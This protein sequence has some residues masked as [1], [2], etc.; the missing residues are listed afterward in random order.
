MSLS[1]GQR[2]ELELEGP[3]GVTVAQGESEGRDHNIQDTCL[4]TVG[5]VEEESGRSVE[6]Q[7]PP[8]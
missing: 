5:R 7:Q 8:R 2:T 6:T 4:V 3:G 1:S